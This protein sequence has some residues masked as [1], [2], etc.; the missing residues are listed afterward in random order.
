MILKTGSR[1]PFYFGYSL[2]PGIQDLH[3][4]GLNKYPAAEVCDATMF[5][6]NTG[7]GLKIKELHFLMSGKKAHLQRITYGLHNLL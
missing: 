4:V 5:N 2:N 1:Y 6:S 7:A 3:F